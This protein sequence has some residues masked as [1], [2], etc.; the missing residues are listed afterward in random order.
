MR[1][2]GLHFGLRLMPMVARLLACT[3]LLG[4]AQSAYA[5]STVTPDRSAG[6]TL[7]QPENLTESVEYDEKDNTFRWG[8]K[9]GD[10]FVDVPTVMTPEEYNRMTFRKS[11]QEYFRQKNNE[12]VQSEGENR[13]DF[14]DLRFDLGPAEKIFGP[15]GVQVKT[16]GSATIKF[17]YNH[18][19]VDNPSLSVQ[20]RRTGGFDFDEQINLSVNASVGDKVNL[21]MNY[22]TEATWTAD[23]KKIKLRYEGKEDEIVRLLEAGNVSFP[24]NS[25]LIKGATSLFGVRSDLQF[26]KLS[27]Q[28]VLSQK[29]SSSTSVSSRGGDQLT[30]FEIDAS[31]Y[32]ENRHFF[33][34]HYFRDN[35]DKSMSMLPTVLSGVRITRIELWVTNKRSNYDDPRN[36]VA[37]SDLGESASIGNSMWNITDGPV[38]SN[39]A[40]DLY[41][42]LNRDYSQIRDLDQVAVTLG[43][44]MTGGTDYE[45]LSNA[46]KLKDNEYTLNAD[47]GFI[48]LRTALTAD[49]VLAVAFE[50]TYN[51]KSY[52][53]G[54]FASDLTDASQSLFVKLLKSNSNVPGSPTWD[55]MMKNVYSITTG[56]INSSK[57]KMNICYSSDSTGSRLTYLPEQSLKSTPLLKLL[58]LD[59]L[60]DNQG[61]H[62]NGK[63]DFVEGYTVLAS[64]GKIIFPVI[65]P[66]GS[67]LRDAIGDDRIAEKYLFQELYDSTKVV[68]SRIAE[69]DKFLLMGEYSGSGGNVIQLGA[70][71]IPRG[72][73]I[74]TAGGVTLVENSDYR[75]DYSSGT[76]TIINQSIIDAGTSVNVQTESN[77]L[78]SIQRKTMAGV[79]WAYDLSNDLQL[80]GTLMHLNEKPLTSKVVM[81]DEPLVNTMYGLNV[82]WKHDSQGL[83]NLVDKLPFVNA[84]APSNIVLKAEMASLKSSVSDRVQGSASYIDDFEEAETGINIAQP[85]AWSLASVPTGVRGSGLTGNVESGYYRSLLNWFTIDPLFTRRNSSLTPSHLKSDLDQL[86][87]HYVREIYERELYPNKETVSSESTTLQVLNLA[88]YPQERGPYNLNPNLDYEGHLQNPEQNWGGIMRKMTTTDFEA[89]NIE[90]IEF[91]MLDPF[92]KNPGSSGGSLFINLGEVSEDVLADGKKFFENGLPVD[93]SEG[94]YES[95]VWGKVPTSKSLVYAFDNNN[96][97]SRA[98]QDVGLN[99][100]SS[101]E[102]R[103]WPAYSDYLNAISSR[104][105]PDVYKT[106]YDDP[107]GDTY[108]YYRGSDYDE[109]KMKILDRYRKYN[110]TEGNSPNSSGQYDSYDQSS[111]TTP[112]VEDANGDF[113]LDEYE[114]YFQYEVSLRPQDLVVGKNY[115]ADRRQ[116][117]IKLRNGNTESVNWYLFRVPL[118]EYQKT[119]GS[120]RDFSSIRFMRMYL[121]GFSEETHI[122]F[123][124]L[125]LMTSEWRNY[126]Q[127]IAGAQDRKAQVSG[128]FTASSVNIEE[129]GDRQPVNYVMPPGITRILAPDQ[130]QLIQDNEQAMSLKVTDLGAGDARAIYK[131]V[132]LDLRKYERL[133]M[134]S[135]AEAPAVGNLNVND[136]DFSVFIRIGSDYTANYYEYEIPLKV[137]AHGFYSSSELDRALVW[138]EENMLDIEFSVLTA[139]KEHRNRERNAGNTNM[140]RI[141]SEYDPSRPANRISVVGNPSIGNV[142]AVMIGVRNNSLTQNSAEVWVNELRLVG[143]ESHGGSAAQGSMTLRLSDIGTATFNGR[144]E[145]AGFGGLE[146]NI[147]DRSTDNR[148]QYAMTTNFNLGRFLPEKAKI[149]VPLYYSYTKESVSPQYSPY[150]TDMYLDDVLD[151]YPEGHLRDSIRSLSQDVR[152]SRNFSI[153]NA[154]VDL[155]SETPMPYDPANFSFS[156]S[157]S[158]QDNHSSTI[159]YEHDENWKAA[160]NYTYSTTLPGWKP[161]AFIEYQSNWLKILKETTINF[162]PQSFVFDTDLYRSYHELQERDLEGS[163]EGTVPVTFSQQFYW[164]RDLTVRW[165]MLKELTMSFTSRT[166]AEIAEPYVVVNK[167]LYPDE[168]EY[169]KDSVR[170]SLRNMGSPLDYQQ[171][172]QANYKVPLSKLPVLNWTDFTMGYNSGYTWNRGIRYEDGSSFGNNIT[173]RRDLTLNGRFDLTTLY[174]KSKYLKSVNERHSGKKKAEA[175]VK[176]NSH[177]QKEYTFLPDSVYVLPHNLATFT[178]K[179]TATTKEGDEVKL[180]FRK[181][182]M[183]NI[184]VKVKDTLTVKIRVIQDP[185]KPIRTKQLNADDFLQFGVR[186]LMGFRNV[187]FSYRDSYNMSLPGFLPSSEYLGQSGAGSMLAPGLDFAF[188][189]IDDSYLYKAKSNGW[190]LQSDSVVQNAQTTRSQDLQVKVVAE[191]FTDVKIDI[192]ASWSKSGNNQVQYGFSGMPSTRSGNFTMTTMTIGSAFEFKNSGNNWHSASYERFLSNLG[193]ISERIEQEYAGARYPEGTSMAGQAYSKADGGVNPYSSDVMVPAFLAA[194]TGRDASKMSLDM[195]PDILSMLPN[196]NM[197]Y[198]G[199]VKIP[200][201]E[202]YF[203]SFNLRHAY[204]SIYSIGNFNTFNSYV[205][206]MNGRG[207]VTDVTSGNPVPSSMFNIGTVSINE[208][209]SPLAGL[210]MTLKNGISGRLEYRKTRILTLSTT[211]VQIVETMSDDITLG[212]GYKIVGLKLLGA[213]P[214]TGRNKV[215]NDLNMNLDLSYRNQS[216][217]CRAIRNGTVQATSGNRA[218]KGSLTADYVYSK[219]VTLNAY[220]EYQSNFPMVSTTAYPTSAYDFGLSIRFSLTR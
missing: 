37:F 31:N 44:V 168:Y 171:S 75:V 16:S 12:E 137:T 134:F 154:S 141:Y 88:Y 163:S 182:D 204:K 39:G 167:D 53:V 64:S 56:S 65:E 179:L 27:L 143:Y 174:N 97:D 18:N 125:E 23:T 147:S 211:A 78:Y 84:T 87:D 188:G 181:V 86:S 180:R 72:S 165:D 29:E 57:F 99:G 3:L 50:F 172:F 79:N 129:N 69:K 196:W 130:V 89:S 214:G 95:T 152:E 195:F 123:G 71:N 62:S 61:R 9:L 217:I 28:M 120:I 102:E 22:N 206:Y 220:L 142:K 74:V 115:I 52:Q 66:F 83:T 173:S 210:D 8:V 94:G 58:G 45:K 98:L 185:D 160:V 162:L 96:A 144:M 111:R 90:Y 139:V 128:L 158:E 34:A 169:W 208:S 5:Q 193:I 146:D 19:N 14:T 24:T 91:W 15:G 155:R 133:Q 6:A 36:I 121:T 104:V 49:E 26:G 157:V 150:D 2:A 149:S 55:L 17:G 33:L 43:P 159:D 153:S 184:S 85:S 4:W 35:F 68:A 93:G 124:T 21:N 116:V 198:A 156:Y 80:G 186:T 192:T 122:R 109:Q 100:L 112:D 209:F 114:K 136:G 199:L 60:D 132:S 176:R 191:P 77:T 194:Y 51:G 103:H 189:M 216:A 38:P 48:S 118:S 148:Y 205:E 197:T 105:S 126:E 40:N 32:D 107:A 25:S 1:S 200:F 70:T 183:N 138:P 215:S 42:R 170:T 164:N 13:F 207:F 46:R 127:P 166:R 161:F 219:M 151:S 212:G 82:N 47:L 140:S 190:L 218:L 30:D 113:T 10:S 201:F 106:I 20:N 67:S 59:R 41:S 119:V 131:K 63:F 202:H 54:E 110:G 177:Y 81:G 108:H 135:H 213:L 73:V 117:Q 203:K 7:K 175:P 145:T 76:V 187:S 11:M 101:E 92:I 178:P